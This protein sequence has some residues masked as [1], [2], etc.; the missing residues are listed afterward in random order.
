MNSRPVLAGLAVGAVTL[1][2]FT[3][4]PASGAP[5]RLNFSAVKNCQDNGNTRVRVFVE[6]PTDRAFQF[7]WEVQIS[8]GKSRRQFL[9]VPDDVSRS[10]FTAF[11]V[12][13]D[14]DA[15]FT[16]GEGGD[17]FAGFYARK[18]TARNC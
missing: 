9:D 4:T 2:V 3:A 15:A 10:L 7:G 1:G 5:E 8:S 18:F 12:P 13:A 6:N 16:I 14:G 11:T 17:E